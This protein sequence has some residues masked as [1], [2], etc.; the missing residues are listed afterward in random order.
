MKSDIPS[1]FHPIQ[2]SSTQQITLALV[3]TNKML[4]RG[5]L[6]GLMFLDAGH[7]ICPSSRTTRIWM[8]G[9][10]LA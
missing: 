8:A 9:M 2:T 10:T 7:H 1:R 3:A 4:A 5:T 6:I